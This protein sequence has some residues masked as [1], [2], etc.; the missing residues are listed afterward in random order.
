VAGCGWACEHPRVLRSVE[1]A[2]RVQDPARAGGRFHNLHW[3]QHLW[4][5]LDCFVCA[6]RRRTTTVGWGQEAAL[7][8]GDSDFPAHPAP[9]Q[10]SAFDRTHEGGHLVLRAVVDFWSAP[11]VDRRDGKPSQPL[12]PTPWVRASLGYLCPDT[13]PE[14]AAGHQDV[15]SNQVLPA[16]VDCQTCGSVI[17]RL[18]EGPTL[19]LRM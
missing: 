13:E 7:C 17:A 11:F 18:E 4:L 19:R 6:R 12:S 2:V 5:S 3:Q 14:H 16:A 9:V 10:L 8:S 1:I 15:S